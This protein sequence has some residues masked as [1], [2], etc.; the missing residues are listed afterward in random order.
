MNPKVTLD[1]WDSNGEI[2][3]IIVELEKAKPYSTLEVYAKIT[4]PD[5]EPFCIR[6]NEMQNTLS[7]IDNAGDEI[8]SISRGRP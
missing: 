2:A 8:M 4:P 3:E 5:G 6:I 1:C 7:L